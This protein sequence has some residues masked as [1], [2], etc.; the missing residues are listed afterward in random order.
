MP[1]KPPGPPFPPPPGLYFPSAPFSLWTLLGFLF[2]RTGLTLL[3]HNQ[4]LPAVFSLFSPE[5]GMFFCISVN[6]FASFCCQ[7]REPSVSLVLIPHTQVG[8]LY[9]SCLSLRWY[10][11]SLLAG[12]CASNC[13]Y[14]KLL[15]KA[16]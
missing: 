11:S 3:L 5:W 8:P 10:C 13:P 7:C 2:N 12:L 14:L 1:G 9:S 4:F 6:C 16:F 15:P